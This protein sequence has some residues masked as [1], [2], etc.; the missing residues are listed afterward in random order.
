MVVLSIFLNQNGVCV[1]VC[2]CVRVEGVGVFKFELLGAQ[3]CW[4]TLYH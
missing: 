4:F 2:V 1:C 3:P